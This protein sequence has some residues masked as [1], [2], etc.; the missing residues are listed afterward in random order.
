MDN[1]TKETYET[2]QKLIL[3]SEWGRTI[4]NTALY[5]YL[6]SEIYE[7]LE[8]CNNRDED[9]ML[10][11]ASDV[12]MILL[13]IVIKNT[14]N[15]QAN[16]IEELLFRTNK[17]LHTRYSV[18]FE[19][20]QDGKEE[21]HWV[22]TKY[23]EKEVLHYLFCPNANCNHYAKTNRGNMVVNGNQVKC[24]TCGYTSLCSSNNIILYKSKYRRKLMDSLDNSYIGY[25]NG[26]HSF[27]DDYLSS[28]H[29]EYV[30]VVR[31]WATNKAGSLA[32]RDYFASKHAVPQ[33]T[34]DEFL[35]SPLRSFMNSELNYQFKPIRSTIKIYDLII[36]LI[37]T[38]YI[39]IK[40]RFCGNENSEYC[41][42]WMSYIR[43][44]IKSMALPI[45]NEPSVGKPPLHLNGTIALLK[46]S[47]VVISN[48]YILSMDVN[49]KTIPA[50]LVFYSGSK[51][52]NGAILWTDIANCKLN[53]QVGQV[54]MSTVLKFNLQHIGNLKCVLLN[55][56][57]NLN[58]EELLAFL[59]DLLPMIDSIE[60][61][62]V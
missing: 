55:K 47:Q 50:Y 13:Y 59:K 58:Q 17:K 10:E 33:E 35:M 45:S 12:L 6:F 22:Q 18:F 57:K 38:N 21:L 46:E 16:L 62:S 24:L 61:Y 5:N 48:A 60:S 27:A 29:E 25:I 53:S 49:K 31:Y 40:K 2:I 54:L 34:F 1:I 11:E 15:S 19:G 43:Q 7:F 9:N 30:K 52:G 42:V 39:E 14:R 51:D 28:Q 41:E 36:K 44:L 37:N 56:K 26:T 8:G 32:L 3:E 4:T 23:L 20:N